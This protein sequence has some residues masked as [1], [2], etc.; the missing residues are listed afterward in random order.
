[1]KITSSINLV[2][3]QNG[4]LSNPPSSQPVLDPNL[5]TL[6]SNKPLDYF[7]FKQRYPILTEKKPCLAQLIT[8]TFPSEI[9]TQLL[10]DLICDVD[11]MRSVQLQIPQFTN[12]IDICISVNGSHYSKQNIPL[13]KSSDLI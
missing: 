10:D 1:V 8:I 9:S 3:S 4:P 7:D 2:V 12:F 6:F 13:I 11:L 5:L